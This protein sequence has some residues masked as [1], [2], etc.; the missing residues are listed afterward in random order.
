L[1]AGPAGAII[2]SQELISH[3]LSF[4]DPAWSPDGARLAFCFGVYASPPHAATSLYVMDLRGF[5]QP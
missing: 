5:L 2:S 1:A 4:E 3:T